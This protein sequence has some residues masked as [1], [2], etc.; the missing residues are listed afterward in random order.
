LERILMCFE[1]KS[2]L[3]K[4]SQTPCEQYGMALVSDFFKKKLLCSVC[5]GWGGLDCTWSMD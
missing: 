2:T 4:H 5:W 1:M 3:K